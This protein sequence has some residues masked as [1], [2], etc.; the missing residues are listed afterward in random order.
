LRSPTHESVSRNLSRFH[1]AVAYSVAQTSLSS[2]S[3][4]LIPSVD[5]HRFVIAA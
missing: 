2:Q 4:L 1:D 5:H 3:I